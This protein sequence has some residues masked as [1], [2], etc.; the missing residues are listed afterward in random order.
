MSALPRSWQH[1]SDK[2]W[3]QPECPSNWFMDK[4]NL[5]HPQTSI[6]SHENDAVDGYILGRR[7]RQANQ[8]RKMQKVKLCRIS[9]WKRGGLQIYTREKGHGKVVVEG[10]V[11]IPCTIWSLNSSRFDFIR[12]C[13]AEWIA[14][15][16]TMLCEIADSN[17]FIFYEYIFTL[18][19]KPEI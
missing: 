7:R 2:T 12:C 11:K 10:Q 5:P 9:W 18:Y 17:H 16:H 15:W 8:N 13:L 4:G 19:Y 14:T 6:Q 1:Y 3:K